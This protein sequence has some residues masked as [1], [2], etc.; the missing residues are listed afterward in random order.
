MPLSG[1]QRRSA[2]SAFS[3]ALRW[4]TKSSKEAR[5]D[6]DRGIVWMGRAGE[7]CESRRR[8][9]GIRTKEGA[10]GRWLHVDGEVCVDRVKWGKKAIVFAASTSTV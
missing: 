10:H 1:S 3:S 7:G 5:T 2:S 4:V 8:V 6:V 9:G